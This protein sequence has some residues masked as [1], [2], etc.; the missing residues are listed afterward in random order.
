MSR[1][2]KQTN[3]GGVGNNNNRNTNV[4]PVVDTQL[5][6]YQASRFANNTAGNFTARNNSGTNQK[7]SLLYNNEASAQGSGQRTIRSTTR[8]AMK[9]TS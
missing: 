2:V 5:K 6:N 4:S 7:K 1:R 8:N 9:S 3:Q